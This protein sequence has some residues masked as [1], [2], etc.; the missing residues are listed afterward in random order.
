M[1]QNWSFYILLILISHLILGCSK[2]TNNYSKSQREISKSMIEYL[3][4]HN[5]KIHKDEDFLKLGIDLASIKNDYKWRVL[6]SEIILRGKVINIQEDSSSNKMFHTSSEIEVKEVIKS[7]NWKPTKKI[8]LKYKTGPIGNLYMISPAEEM[9]KK[10]EEVLLYLQPISKTFEIIDKNKVE[11]KRRDNIQQ[12]NAERNNPNIF[13][14]LE[15]YKIKANNKILVNGRLV[16][17]KKIKKQI[18]RI[19]KLNS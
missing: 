12:I 5:V 3:N 15:K 16:P 2:S 9:V 4:R 14:P 13:R 6:N 7:K 8:L 11:S 10:G 18:H 19:N 1:K 17:F